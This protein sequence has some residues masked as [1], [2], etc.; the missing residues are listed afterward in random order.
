MIINF[1]E[2]YQF[3]TRLQQKNQNIQVVDKI[4]ILGTTFNNKITWDENCS[5]IIRKVKARMQLLRKVWS[6]GSSVTEMVHLWR[7]YC[8]SILEQSCVVWGNLLT[9]DNKLDLERTQKSFCKLVLEEDYKNYENALITLQLETLDSRRKKLTL[10]FAKTS[11]A[12]G[13]FHDLIKKKKT[14]KG[15]H[16]RKKEHYNVTFAHTDGYR[17]SPI[18]T[19]QRLLNQ[20]HKENQK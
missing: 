9:E 3:H 15:P 13:H 10:N 4:K 2:K 19:M 16:T 7:T 14:R 11:L 8:L 6:F 5:I 18:L 17:R 12:D 20:N 1:T